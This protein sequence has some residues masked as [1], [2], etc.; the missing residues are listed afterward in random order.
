MAQVHVFAG[1]T[2]ATADPR[3]STVAITFNTPD[4]G[5]DKDDDTKLGITIF[6][7]LGSSGFIRKLAF[8]PLQNDGRFADGSVNMVNVPVQGA[9]LLSSITSDVK[10]KIEFE[11]KGDDTWKFKYDLDLKFDDGTVLTKSSNGEK[12]LSD[13]SRVLQE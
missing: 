1:G 10:L 9:V 3:L 5:N 6:T 11:P 13:S 8:R 4:G 7:T 2:D 12:T